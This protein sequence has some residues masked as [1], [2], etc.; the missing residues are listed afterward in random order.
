MGEFE[1]AWEDELE[2]DEEIVESK[3]EEQNEDGMYRRNRALSRLRLTMI[4]Y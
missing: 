3:D 4:L 2:S 1:D